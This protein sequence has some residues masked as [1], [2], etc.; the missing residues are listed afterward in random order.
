MQ[1]FPFKRYNHSL[2]VK[3]L[4]YTLLLPLKYTHVNM[5]FL[6]QHAK[7]AQFRIGKIL[8]RFNNS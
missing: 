6:Q 2:L 1:Y 5:I 8:L 3:L 7:N 4:K